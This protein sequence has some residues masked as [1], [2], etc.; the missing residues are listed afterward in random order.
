MDYILQRWR[1]PHNFSIKMTVGWMAEFAD[2]CIVHLFLTLMMFPSNC[3]DA[4]T[5]GAKVMMTDAPA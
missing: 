2:R 1:K 3:I 5:H 4:T